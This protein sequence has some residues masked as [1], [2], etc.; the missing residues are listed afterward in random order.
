MMSL[1]EWLRKAFDKDKKAATARTSKKAERGKE[2][3][4]WSRDEARE[5]F[6]MNN[7]WNYDGS[8]QRDFEEAEED[9]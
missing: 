5:R 7:F 4:R 3:R 6:Y 8:E 9:L 1:G 2:R